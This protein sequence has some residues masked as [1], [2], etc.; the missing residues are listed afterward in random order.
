MAGS[1][2]P[3]VMSIETFVEAARVLVPSWTVTRVED[4]SFD[5]SE[6]IDDEGDEL[7]GAP[8]PLGA[9]EGIGHRGRP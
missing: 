6:L 4:V 3:G 8:A 2:L 7:K 5:E 9:D 1:V